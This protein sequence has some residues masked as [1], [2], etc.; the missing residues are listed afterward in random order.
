MFIKAAIAA[1]VLVVLVVLFVVR[2]R[3]R[4]A[5]PTGTHARQV[6]VG[7]L[8]YRARERQLRD[9]FEPF[10]KI[11]SLRLMKDRNT[12]RSRGFAFITF[13]APQ[14]AKQSLKLHGKEHMGR[15][16]VVRPALEKQYNA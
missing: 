5:A 8:S 15:T 7:N 1:L 14:A 9:T 2:Y 4:A 10:G 3:K 12:G 13:D 11:A 16:L 6:Y